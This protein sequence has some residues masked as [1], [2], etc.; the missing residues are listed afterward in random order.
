MFVAIAR[1]TLR[2]EGSHSLKEKRAVVRRAV[3]RVQQRFHAPPQRCIVDTG[4]G[5]IRRSLVLPQLVRRGEDGHVPTGIGIH[6]TM[7]ITWV[8]DFVFTRTPQ[9]MSVSS[10]L[11]PN[12]YKRDSGVERINVG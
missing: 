10:P 5:Q 2:I 1:F 11:S 12:Q 4:L 6:A 8:S 9:S 7:L 3:D